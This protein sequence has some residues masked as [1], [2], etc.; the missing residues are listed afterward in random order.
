MK[1]KYSR[2]YKIVDVK[3]NLKFKFMVKKYKGFRELK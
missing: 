1:P 3:G 2:G